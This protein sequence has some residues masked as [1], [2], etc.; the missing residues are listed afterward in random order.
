MGI[1]WAHTGTIGCIGLMTWSVTCYAGVG[2]AGQA[3]Q[4]HLRSPDAGR[5]PPLVHVYDPAPIGPTCPEAVGSVGRPE[6]QYTPA[7]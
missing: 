5:R 4:P 3:V 7:R 2:L 6:R 1:L